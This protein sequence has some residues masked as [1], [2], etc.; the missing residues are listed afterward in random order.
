MKIIKSNRAP[1]A[2]GP[3]SQA[4]QHENLIFCS[5]QIALKEDGSMVAG[6]I[7]EQTE[8]VLKN[9]ENV[10]LAGGTSLQKV[11]KTTVYLTDLNNFAKMNEIYGR[12]FQDHKPARATVGVTALP[13]AALVEI[14]CIAI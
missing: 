5:G 6:G 2:I 7:E 13:K 1:K 14:D 9:L 12:Y 3:Y 8:Q 10:L 11:V 4:I